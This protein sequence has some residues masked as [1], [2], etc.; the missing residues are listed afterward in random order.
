MVQATDGAFYGTTYSGGATDSACGG[1]G[2]VFKITPSGALTTLA[3]FDSADGQW[4][5]A[6]LVQAT[7]RGLLRDHVIWRRQQQ[8]GSRRYRLQ[9][10]QDRHAD[11]AVQFPAVNS[12]TRNCTDGNFPYS[13]LVQA[14]NGDFYGTTSS[15]G[16]YCKAGGCG[17]V[18]K[19]TPSGAMTTVFKFDG[20]DGEYSMVGLVQATN[21]DFYGTASGGGN[22]CPYSSGCGTVFSLS[23]GLGPFVKTVP[24]A[25]EVILPVTVLGTDLTGATSVTFNGTPGN[26]HCELHGNRH[27][28][29]RTRLRDHRNGAGGGH[30]Q[31]HAFE[32][33]AVPG[34]AINIRAAA[35][36]G[37]AKAEQPDCRAEGTAGSGATVRSQGTVP[38]RAAGTDGSRVEQKPAGASAWI[39]R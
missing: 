32:Q 17:T 4:P 34:V 39:A 30:T 35:G 11:A 5:A 21:G 9:N 37:V 19:I 31:R 7:N 6:G 26:V 28:D 27:H 20:T 8:Q 33:R 12:P 3:S 2:T 22:Y 13:A 14:T 29:H 24:N 16:N 1:C 38:R 15:G 10:H 25:G 18:F 23:V 36:V